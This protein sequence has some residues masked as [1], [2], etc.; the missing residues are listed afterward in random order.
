MEGAWA[1]II[2][3]PI[4]K[5]KQRMAV[6]RPSGL[7]KTSKK[8]DSQGP[9][10]QNEMPNQPNSLG[11]AWKERKDFPL[12]LNF[13]SFLG[14]FVLTFSQN[15]WG[16]VSLTQSALQRYPSTKVE[17]RIGRKSVNNNDNEP[18]FSYTA[19]HL[20]HPVL[21]LQSGPGHWVSVPYMTCDV[22]C[23]CDL[24]GLHS[25]LELCTHSWR[26]LLIIQDMK[27]FFC[28]LLE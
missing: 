19:H 24:D 16:G 5:S 1:S 22:S 20:S 23:G 3:L 7:S 8:S 14:V 4:P 27:C 17:L 25:I 12:V 11:R 2:C 26:L 15:I 18:S 6:H 13:P 21:D 9:N 28:C 10:A